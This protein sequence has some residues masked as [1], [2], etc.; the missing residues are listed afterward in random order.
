MSDERTERF[1]AVKLFSDDPDLHINSM[2]PR[3]PTML[4]RPMPGS[5]VGPRQPQQ[6]SAPTPPKKE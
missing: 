6:P 5:G 4:D 3:Q 2:G 1:F